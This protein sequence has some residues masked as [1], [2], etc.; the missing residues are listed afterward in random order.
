MGH[1]KKEM[2]ITSVLLITAAAYGET[3][4]KPILEKMPTCVRPIDFSNGKFVASYAGC[5]KRQDEF[6]QKHKENKTCDARPVNPG[7]P[8]FKTTVDDIE[9]RERC[10]VNKDGSYKCLQDPIRIIPPPTAEAP[11]IAGGAPAAGGTPGA[12]AGTPSG[13]PTTITVPVE[14]GGAEPGAMPPVVRPPPPQK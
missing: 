13:G 7:K 4:P 10:K 8:Y 12:P 3:P 11:T 9:P 6:C 14:E 5:L 1:S 2:I